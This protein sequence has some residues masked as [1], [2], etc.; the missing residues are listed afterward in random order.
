MA[1]TVLIRELNG[2]TPTATDK[3]SGTIRFKGADNATVDTANR[4]VVPASG[5]VYSF[6]KVVRLY[7]SVAPDVDIDDLEAYTDGTGFGTGIKGWYA[8]TATHTTPDAPST[9]NDPPQ[10]PGAT[11]MTDLFGAT[12]GSPIDMDGNNAGPYTEIGEIGDYLNMVLEVESTASPGTLSAETLTF[13]FL[14]T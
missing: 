6:R 4:L 3:T 12:S 11:P 2:A 7:I 13:S 14:E 8:V 9:S 10:F 1:A 5:Q